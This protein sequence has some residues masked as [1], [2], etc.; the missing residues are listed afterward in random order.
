MDYLYYFFGILIFVAVVLALE[1]GFLVWNA[2]KG[3]EAARVARRLRSMTA[4]GEVQQ[5]SMIKQR[6]LA[7][8][9]E[10]QRLMEKVPNVN[11]IDTLI[12]Q[13]GLDWTVAYL[14]GWS[15]AWWFIGLLS[16]SYVG[17]AWPIRFLIAF[18]F[19]AL[20]TMYV[21]RAKSQRL[22]KIEEQLPDAMDVMGRALRAGHAF[23]TALKMVGE[24][25]SA[26]LCDEFR[27]AFD[28]VNFG[29]SMQEALT[30][31]AARVPI[32]DL[33]YFVVAVVIQRETGGNL[34]EL[35]AS[36]SEIMRDRIKLFAKVRVLSAEGRMSA[37]IL[38]LLPFGAGLLIQ[39][40]NPTFLSILFTDPIGQKMLASSMFM[41]A[42]GI[43][44]MRKII[45][46]RV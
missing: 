30:N 39:L 18:A 2:T 42:V 17:V 29:F 24:E 36:I 27:A 11:S 41:M 4:R 26:P 28:E 3:P 7:K 12:M 9:P 31:M 38:S 1:G 34:A 5:A 25:A 16:A 6:I 23:P 10:L 15:L 19:A 22:R 46:I 37:W 14:M 8:T 44:F 40:T 35:L 20:P 32:T 43:L 33:R 13:S 45:Q 21:K